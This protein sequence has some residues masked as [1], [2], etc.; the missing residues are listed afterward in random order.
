ML[1]A[2]PIS[3]KPLPTPSDRG[4]GGAAQLII[5]AYVQGGS[6]ERRLLIYRDGNFSLLR[7]A[8]TG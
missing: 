1:Q 3:G 7:P 6:D 2:R 8:N 4:F 5:N